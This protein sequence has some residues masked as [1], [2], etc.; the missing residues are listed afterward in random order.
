MEVKVKDDTVAQRADELFDVVDKQDRVTGQARRADVHARKLLHRAI[1]VLVFDRAG[2]VFLQRRSMAKDVAPGRWDSSCSGHLDAGEDY[3]AAAVRELGEE[4]GLVLT[5]PPERWLRLEACAQ[6]GWEF[7]WVYRMEHE[8]PFRLHPAEIMD[9][10]WYERAE[11]DRAMRERARDFA[12]AFRY[13]WG[14]LPEG[15]AAAPV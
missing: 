13:I 7:V 6:T 14:R 15:A 10:A 1:H 3:D 11:V 5:A 2:R 8:G 9:G 12:G 4:I